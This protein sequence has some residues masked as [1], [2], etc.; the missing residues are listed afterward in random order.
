[1]IDLVKEKIKRKELVI[2]TTVS[3]SDAAITEMFVN[4]GFDLIWVDFEHSGF[5]KKEIFHHLLAMRQSKTA[6]IVRV[7]WNDPVL[8]K[9]ILDMGVDGIIFPFI[10]TAQEAELAVSSC[11][12]PPKGIRGFGPLGANKYGTVN[13]Q[14]YLSQADSQIWKVMQIEHVD[15]VR[16]L[17]AIVSVEGVDAIVIGA[18]DLAASIGLIGQT[19]H[20]AVVELLD[21]IVA[22]CK[23]KEVPLGISLY[24]PSDIQ[25]WVEKG[26]DWIV[27]GGDVGYLK[28]SA[29]EVLEATKAYWTNHKQ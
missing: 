12:Y 25:L 14:D 27:A 5:D 22:V 1:M 20:P 9:P 4:V 24:D 3:L 13:L 28:K 17:E 21:Q 8:V 15:G 18:N 16:N 29:C 26:V 23:E 7:P 19:R 6:A 11:M 2:G 10:K